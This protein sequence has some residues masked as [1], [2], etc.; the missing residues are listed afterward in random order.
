MIHIHTSEIDTA[1]LFS[2]TT[3]A[4]VELRS[5]KTPSRAVTERIVT[6][7]FLRVVR[8]LGVDIGRALFV[9]KQAA[10]IASRLDMNELQDLANR[11]GVQLDETEALPKK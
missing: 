4:Q 8:P 9:A 2:A 1:V 6:N 7:E 3:K 11:Y 10:K 5:G